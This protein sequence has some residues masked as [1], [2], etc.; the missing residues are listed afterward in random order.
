M[1]LNI[2]GI[3]KFDKQLNNAN[4]YNSMLD[5]KYIISRFEVNNANNHI[6]DCIKNPTIG[7]LAR[8][9]TQ[10]ND[11]PKMI[12]ANKNVLQNSE[13]Y[14]TTRNLFVDSYMSN[15]PKTGKARMFLIDN[16]YIVLNKV[17][18]IT[19]DFKRNVFKKF[20]V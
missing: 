4:I 12:K 9:E 7:L 6:L 14:M 15:Y 13:K 5:S 10:T 11:C 19:K 18:K 16:H 8:T 20:G 1:S 17:K 3:G 2:L